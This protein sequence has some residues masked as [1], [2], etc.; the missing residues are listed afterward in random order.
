MALTFPITTVGTNTMKTIDLS[1][2]ASLVN[3]RFYRQGLNWA[4][5][6]FTLHSTAGTGSISISRLPQ[7]WVTSQAW[8]K[9]MRIWLRQ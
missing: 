7:T 9:T 8:E 6:G 5:A 1:Q 2:C 3:R 4:V